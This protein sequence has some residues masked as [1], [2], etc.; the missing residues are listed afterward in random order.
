[1]TAQQAR[2]S[3]CDVSLTYLLRWRPAC[4]VW[5]CARSRPRQLDVLCSGVEHLDP[6]WV[7]PAA[8][9]DADAALPKARAAR[10]RRPR[11]FVS[12]VA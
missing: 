5:F 6:A 2:A 7:T 4:R 9:S 10:R 8:R 11:G 3:V 12:W 1:M